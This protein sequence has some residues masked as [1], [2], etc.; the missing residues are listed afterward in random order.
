MHAVKVKGEGRILCERERACVR[1][2]RERGRRKKETARNANQ[3]ARR[4]A[5]APPASVC[6]Y[7]RCRGRGDAFFSK[8][9]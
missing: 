5:D 8:Q 6:V 7:E 1:R 2:V 9:I 3:F 4:G